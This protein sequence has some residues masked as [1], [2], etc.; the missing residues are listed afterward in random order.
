MN[1]TTASRTFQLLTRLLDT[2]SRTEPFLPPNGEK[3]PLPLRLPQQPFPR[4]TPESQG[5]SSDHI[6]KFLEELARGEDLYMQDVLILRHGQVLCEAAFGGQVLAA[7]KY[8]FSACKSVV[9]LAVGLLIDD[10]LLRLE[11]KVADLFEDLLPPA[12]RRRLRSM[13]VEDLLTMRSGIVFSEA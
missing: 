11:D 5:V 3:K 7:P 4:A 1:L 9:S 12:S 10:G 6:R 8:T 2:R 13:S